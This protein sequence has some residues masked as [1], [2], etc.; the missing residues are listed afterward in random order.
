M[1]KFLLVLT[2][3][4]GLVATACGDDATTDVGSNDPPTTSLT[5]DTVSDDPVSDDPDAGGGDDGP[6]LGAGPYP[7]ADLTIAVTLTEGGGTTTSRLACL[8]DTATVTGD[9]GPA[10]SET[11]CL[12]LDNPSIKDRIVN[13]APTD[14]ACTEQYGGPEI[15]TISGTFDGVDVDTSFDRANGCGIGDWEL[16]SALLPTRA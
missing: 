2:V 6:I 5:D 13:G 1:R 9:P 4:V 8:G 3:A 15:A 16:L 14:V 11:M 10:S 12:A 7:I